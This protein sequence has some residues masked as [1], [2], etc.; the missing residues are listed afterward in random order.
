MP[1]TSSNGRAAE[2]AGTAAVA[3]AFT[4]ASHALG[5]DLLVAGVRLGRRVDERLDHLVVG[6]VPVGGIAP[7]LAVPGV[8]P[9]AVH[10]RVVLARG[11]ERLDHVAESAP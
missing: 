8:D 11:L 2:G 6:L 3:T 4:L 7:I 5:R 9:A 1:F 10:A